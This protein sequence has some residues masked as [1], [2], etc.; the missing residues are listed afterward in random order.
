[1]I[2]DE[3]VVHAD[4]PDCIRLGNTAP[5]AAYLVDVGPTKAMLVAYLF[6][7]GYLS[8]VHSQ[9]IPPSVPGRTYSIVFIGEISIGTHS[10]LSRPV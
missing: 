10:L 8:R 3:L 1:M 5:A 6:S 7:R 9:F 4:G 2:G